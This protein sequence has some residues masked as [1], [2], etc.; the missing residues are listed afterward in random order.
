[1]QGQARGDLL[2]PDLRLAARGSEQRHRQDFNTSHYA[3]N[4]KYNNLSLIELPL[5][6]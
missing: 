4:P 3:E 1:M 2:K 5:K 6:I